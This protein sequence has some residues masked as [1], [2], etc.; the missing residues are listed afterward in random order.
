MKSSN[1][2]LTS[3]VAEQLV[4]GG[5]GEVESYVVVVGEISRVDV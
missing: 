5:S 4:A 1:S 3:E 2:L